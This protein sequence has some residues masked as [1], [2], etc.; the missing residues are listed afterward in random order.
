[1]RIIFEGP[2]NVGKSTLI[3]GIIKELKI[4]FLCLHSYAPPGSLNGMEVENFH[5]DL[6]KSMFKVMEDNKF[7]IADRF[8]PGSYVYSKLYDRGISGDFVLDLELKESE[9]EYFN[10]VCM[11]ILIDTPENLVI[12]EDGL[13]IMTG[14]DIKKKEVSLY[15]EIF[16]KVSIK[17]KVLIN[18]ENKSEKEVLDE[19][20]GKLKEFYE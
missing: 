9:K 6:Y 5:T 11:V 3:R 20:I 8:Y 13:S 12:R 16:D 15:N 2:D 10:D 18:V 19:V 14:I 1:M 4:P 7:V 17:K